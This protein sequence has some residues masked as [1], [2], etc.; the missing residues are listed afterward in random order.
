[1]DDISIRISFHPR[2]EICVRDDDTN[3][4]YEYHLVMLIVHVH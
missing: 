2:A 1:M 4:I 3:R